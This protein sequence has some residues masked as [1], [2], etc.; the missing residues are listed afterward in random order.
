M[1]ENRLEIMVS[2]FLWWGT[3]ISALIIGTGMALT[4]I[5]GGNTGY[6]LGTYPTTPLGIMQGILEFRPGAVQSLGFVVLLFIPIGRI[7]L[8]SLGYLVRKEYALMVMSWLALGVITAGLLLG[9]AH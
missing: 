4:L 3:V 9:V 6:P 5:Q 2:S 8:L 7:L 1:S